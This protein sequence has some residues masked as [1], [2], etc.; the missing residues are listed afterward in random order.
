[1]QVHPGKPNDTEQF[2]ARLHD[3]FVAAA[4]L[5]HVG[6]KVFLGNVFHLLDWVNGFSCFFQDPGGNVGCINFQMPSLYRKMFQ[7]KHSQR[8]RFLAAGATCTPN[9]NLSRTLS[10]GGLLVPSREDTLREKVE[11]SWFPE[12]MSLVRGNGVEHRPAFFL[13]RVHEA[14]I[15]REISESQCSKA[16]GEPP[17]QQSCLRLR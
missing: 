9:A 16:L 4:T 7:Q 2:R 6:A 14:V 1:M 8:V 11:V 5:E 13:V 3:A 12:E 15:L 10:G 17:R